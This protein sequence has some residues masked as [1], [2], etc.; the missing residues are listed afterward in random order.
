MKNP[1]RG[2]YAASFLRGVGRVLDLRGAT[3]GAYVAARR[4]RAAISDR[5]A[6][7]SD[8][9]AVWGDLDAAFAKVRR[10]DPGPLHGA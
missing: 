7:A 9:A 4:T 10:D 1:R 2:A 5:A 6:L 8:W 3:T